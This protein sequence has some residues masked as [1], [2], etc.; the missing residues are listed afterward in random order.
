MRKA[1]ISEGSA[2]NFI[3]MKKL[4][5]GVV[6][7]AVTIASYAQEKKFNDTTYLQPVE[8]NAVR[9]DS[10]APF[11]KTDLTKKEI[12]KNNLGQD[13]PF[14]LNQTPGVVINSDA[15]NGVGCI[16]KA[17]TCGEDRAGGHAQ[18]A[19]KGKTA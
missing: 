3:V 7:C 5:T 13:L 17:E 19:G 10:K 4:L 16:A 8:V 18:Q 9:A 14:L 1:L 6:L 15:G 12:E 2:Y 11:A